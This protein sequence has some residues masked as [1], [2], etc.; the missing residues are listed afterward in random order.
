MINSVLNG[1]R[2]RRLHDI[3]AYEKICLSTSID[4]FSMTHHKAELCNGIM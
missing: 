4:K 2:Q 1:L 3:E